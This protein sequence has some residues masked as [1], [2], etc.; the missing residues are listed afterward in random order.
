MGAKFT[1]KLK[2]LKKDWKNTRGDIGKDTGS[3]TNVPEGD[4]EVDNLSLELV[5]N[6]KGDLMIKRTV[7]I[8]EGERLG[9]KIFD[10]VQLESSERSLEFAMK[11]F[12]C[13]GYDDMS[14]EELEEI[15]VEVSENTSAIYSITHK[16]KNDFSD[17]YF[18]EIT[19]EGAMPATDEQEKEAIEESTTDKI[20]T[21]ESSVSTS[22]IDLD[23]ASMDEMLTYCSEKNLWV[24]LGT[25]K[26]KA[27]KLD[28]DDFAEMIKALNSGGVAVE[29]VPAPQSRSRSKKVDVD[30]DIVDRVRGI[31]VSYGLDVK[32]DQGLSVM[33]KTLKKENVKFPEKELEK[34]E[35][36]AMKI[37]NLMAFVKTK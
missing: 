24:A 32:D 21:K 36:E 30:Q 1:S 29:P 22:D 31:M 18:N 19:S 14:V 7:T 6:S 34:E 12:N 23:E 33:K 28:E 8:C 2:S 5:D 37:A 3:F 35:L 15:C 17:V 27:K 13:I 11:F 16:I 4:Y 20:I 10:N 9:V 25:T 26:R